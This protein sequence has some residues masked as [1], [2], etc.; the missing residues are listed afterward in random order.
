MRLAAFIRSDAERILREWEEFVKTLRPGAVLPRWLLRAYGAAILQ[1]IADAIERP[2]RGPE[3]AAQTRGEATAAPIERVAAV[4]VDLRIESGFDLAQIIAEYRA[5][6]SSILR[7]WRAGEPLAHGAE[8]MS[9]LTEAIDQAVEQTVSIYEEREAR[10]RDRF[11][12]MLG[13]DL[14]NP[15]N[16]ILLGAVAMSE[17]SDLD[18]RQRKTVARILGSVRRL[19]RMVSDILDFARGRLGSAM[20]IVLTPINLGTALR[21]IADEVQ[22]AN[23]GFAIDLV[24]NGELRGEWDPERL[25]QAVSNLLLNAIQHG[26]G[27]RVALAATGDEDAVVL[28]VHNEGPPIPREMVGTIFDPLVHGRNSDQ[29]RTGLGLGL[30]IVNEIVSAHRGTIAVTSS[31]EAG[32]TFSVRLPRHQS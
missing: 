22:S 32:T 23:P 20:P 15:L 18:D 21:E 26:S 28:E 7:L 24:V 12:G 27:N 4:H 9:R 30:F 16:S 10:Y 13:H 5:L 19:D 29:S 31:A 3:Q 25:K 2:E 1:S 17:A 11:L 14:R 6:R 8:E